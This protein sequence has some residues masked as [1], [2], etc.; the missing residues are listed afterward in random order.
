MKGIIA[1]VRKNIKP[2]NRQYISK[3]L[4]I[5]QQVYTLLECKGW[6]QKEFARRMKKQESEISKWLS[7]R[8][9]LTLKSITQMETVLGEDIIMTGHKACEKFGKATRQ[10]LGIYS[11]PSDCDEDDTVIFDQDVKI[12]KTNTPCII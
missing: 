1:S 4:D 11:L 9:N 3:N 12:K 2:E 8:H 5:S 6:S 7:G 10:S